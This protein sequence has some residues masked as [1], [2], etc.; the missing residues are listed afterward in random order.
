MVIR[1]VIDF[2]SNFG[3]KKKMTTKNKKIETRLE[4]ETRAEFERLADDLGVSPYTA[5]QW[6]IDCF[7]DKYKRPK[8]VPMKFRGVSGIIPDDYYQKISLLADKYN[9][10]IIDVVSSIINRAIERMEKQNSNSE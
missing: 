3:K 6:A 1:S 9:T 7:I 4:P 2:I 8:D 10:T 5:V